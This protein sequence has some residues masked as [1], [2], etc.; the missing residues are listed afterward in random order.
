MAIPVAIYLCP[1]P[2]HRMRDAIDD[3]VPGNGIEMK[4]SENGSGKGAAVVAAMVC[5]PH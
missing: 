1:F 5:R 2:A 4:I 3:L